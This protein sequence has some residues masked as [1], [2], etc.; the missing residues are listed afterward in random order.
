MNSACL[1]MT[2]SSVGIMSGMRHDEFGLRPPNDSYVDMLERMTQGLQVDVIHHNQPR[3]AGLHGPVRR[4][5][6]EDESSRPSS[7]SSRGERD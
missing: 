5:P 7:R 4:A 3:A 1:D 2:Q 6:T